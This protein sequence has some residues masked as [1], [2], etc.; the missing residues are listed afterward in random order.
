MTLETQ[1]QKRIMRRGG[2][3]TLSHTQTGNPR[4]NAIQ[5]TYRTTGVGA[6]VVGRGQRQWQWRDPGSRPPWAAAQWLLEQLV[7]SINGL[8][9]SLLFSLSSFSLL[10]LPFVWRQLKFVILTR[11]SC[12]PWLSCDPSGSQSGQKNLHWMVTPI[13]LL[14]IKDFN[15]SSVDCTAIM[16][17]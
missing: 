11:S 14:P 5:N 10:S 6:G 8:P 1:T 7:V 3:L 12:L 2:V 9:L 17:Y 16:P 13:L 4:S 15:F